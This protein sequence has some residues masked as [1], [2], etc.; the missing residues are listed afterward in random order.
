[1]V[2]SSEVFDMKGSSWPSVL[3]MIDLYSLNH[4]SASEVVY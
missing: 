1:M 3:I 4:L 2:Q